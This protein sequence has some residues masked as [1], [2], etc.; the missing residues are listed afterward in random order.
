MGSVS[1]FHLVDEDGNPLD[2]RVIAVALKLERKILRT[3]GSSC[4]PA[5]LSDEVE[6]AARATAR[7]KHQVRDFRSF[8]WKSVVNR[9]LNVVRVGSKEELVQ[10]SGLEELVG[11]TGS[12]QIIAYVLAREVLR[13]MSDVDR[14]VMKLRSQD[15][16]AAEIG[17]LLGMSPEAVWT[18]IYRVRQ[19]LEKAGY[20]KENG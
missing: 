7:K 5:V 16:T 18:R 20:T 11:R 12:E 19:S 3:F 1:R 10:P 4:D 17:R 2:E 15:F 9:L 6:E 13:T 14:E 8:F